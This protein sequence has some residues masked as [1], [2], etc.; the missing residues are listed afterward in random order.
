MKTYNI[1]R[2]KALTRTIFPFQLNCEEDKVVSDSLLKFCE[3]A[4]MDE[5]YLRPTS[6]PKLLALQTLYKS[7]KENLDDVE[8]GQKTSF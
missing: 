8:E 4:E 3:L 5:S 6:D 1:D 7:F 2:H